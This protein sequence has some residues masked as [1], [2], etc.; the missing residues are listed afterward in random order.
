MRKPKPSGEGRHI[1][2][3]TGACRTLIEKNPEYEALVNEVFDTY[4]GNVVGLG[5]YQR[6]SPASTS[7]STRIRRSA[8]IA[9]G[10]VRWGSR[11]TTS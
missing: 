1:T 4:R 5:E 9:T 11:R 6:R 2:F 3:G 7:G 10:A 8:T